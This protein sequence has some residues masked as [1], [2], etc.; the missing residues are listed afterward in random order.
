[1]NG[2]M[3][4]KKIFT[5]GNINVL[6]LTPGTYFLKVIAGSKTNVLKFVKL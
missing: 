1:M 6:D 2:K 4:I 3:M 5:T